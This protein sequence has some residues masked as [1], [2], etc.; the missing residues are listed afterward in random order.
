MTSAADAHT[1]DMSHR[2]KVYGVQM[3]LRV[4]C[5][6]GVFLIDNL[7]V[8]VLLILGAAVLPWLAVMLANRGADRSQRTGSAYRPPTRTELPTV[9]ETRDVSPDAGDV[10][11]DGEYTVHHA[12][13]QLP[14]PD[15]SATRRN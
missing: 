9:A 6:I 7:T 13:R 11:V 10:V 2:M 14:G 15:P 5:I 1:T 12:P 8:R 3:A 4:A